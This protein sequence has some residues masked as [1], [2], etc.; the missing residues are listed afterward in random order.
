M[1][2][3]D[4]HEDLTTAEAIDQI[5]LDTLRP[6][7]KL[8]DSD[9]PTRKQDIVPFLAKTLANEDVV[10]RLYESLNETNKAVV[11]EALK[12]PMGRLDAERF[13]AKS[14][15]GPTWGSERAP[16]ALGLLMPSGSAVPRDMRPILSRFV[17]EPR[18]L[19]I[20]GEE[21]LPD[22]V[23]DPVARWWIPRGE[24]AEPIPLRR[25]LT[26]ASAS[27]ELT[28]MLRLAESG[29][30]KVSDKTRKPTEA[31]VGTIAPLLVG[32]DF[33]GREDTSEYRDDPG[34]VLTIRAFAW[35]CLLQAA[36]LVSVSGGKLGLSP[37]GRKALTLPAHEVLRTAWDKWL[38]T[39]LFDEF[40]RIDAIKGKKT[41]RL[42]AAAGRRAA[43]ND[44]LAQ[45][46]PGRWIAIDEFFRVVQAV[47]E[48]FSVAREVWKLYIA[49][50]N[51][52]SFEYDR[53]GSWTMLQ[54]QFVMAMVFEYAATLGLID[55]AYIPPQGARDDYTDH[56]GTDDYECLSRYDGLKFIRINPLG[57]Y[58]LGLAPHY[59]P[60][61][62][63][64][65]KTWRVLPNHEVVSTEESPDP[66]DTL[67]LQR[68]A[69]QTSHR[70]WRLDRERILAA[71][72]DGLDVGEVSEFLEARTA[73]PIPATVA[74]LLADLQD[75]A[76]RLRDKGTVH[77]I[78]CADA[79]TARLLALDPK[80]KSLCLLAGERNLVFRESDESAVRA[81]LRKLG[82]VLP[83]WV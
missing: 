42:T 65:R 24:S 67:F 50:S 53:G 82:Y 9:A 6:L 41:A 3:R 71:V 52:G 8:V 72:E 7:A 78:E 55:V 61:P 12:R 4:Q 46:P 79:E 31:T 5:R 28:T 51:Y 36:G 34:A 20:S 56:W 22:T 10:R 58:V 26:A 68:V 64:A 1:A 21:E 49:D 44:V 69:E 45:L 63:T 25:R 23:P 48:D 70:V 39:S 60:E 13:Q 19:A 32:G 2:Y 27:R 17:P 11:Q 40:E 54:G 76:G 16:T 15:R 59:E 75:R 74:T 29:K 57:A 30:L 38:K 73:E 83:T 37:A 77:M 81:R 62:L 14:G 18:P 66:G 35:P 47:G 43:I 80:L 33:Y